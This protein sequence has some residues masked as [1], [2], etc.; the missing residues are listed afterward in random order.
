MDIL[1]LI[2]GWFFCHYLSGKCWWYSELVLAFF[3][4]VK[5]VNEKEY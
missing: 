5:M 3:S 2:I 1:K 4:G